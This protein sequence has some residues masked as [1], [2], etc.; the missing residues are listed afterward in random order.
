MTASLDTLKAALEQELGARI[1]SYS[2]ARGE[3]TIVVKAADLVAA[4]T[5]LRDAAS[6]QT[7]RTVKLARQ[8][9]GLQAPLPKL[10]GPT[11]DARV[12]LTTPAG[13]LL[14]EF[15]LPVTAAKP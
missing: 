7:P 15:T 4:C 3:A 2:D 10:D 5:T 12:D 14:I 13:P 1:V 11:V 6:P 8:G 9:D